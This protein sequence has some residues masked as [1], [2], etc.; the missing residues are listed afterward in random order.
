MRILYW[1]TLICTAKLYIISELF[2]NHWE[3]LRIALE[4]FQN[5]LQIIENHWRIISE[6]FANHQKCWELLKNYFRMVCKSLRIISEWFVS[7]WELLK[8]YLK[9]VLELILATTNFKSVCLLWECAKRQK[10]W[11]HDV[12]TLILCLEDIVSLLCSYW[13]ENQ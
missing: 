13:P 12:S 2:M 3:S 5:G 10:W 7:H 9:I 11:H 4:S 1:F 6:W 8:N